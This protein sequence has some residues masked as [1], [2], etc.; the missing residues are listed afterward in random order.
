MNS[1]VKTLTGRRLLQLTIIL[2]FVLVLMVNSTF[3]QIK[4]EE[5]NW[6]YDVQFQQLPELPDQHGFAG[7][8]AGV[9]DGK[10]LAGGGANFPTALPWEGGKKVYYDSIFELDKVDGTW[11]K[12]D[13]KLPTPSGYFVFGTYHDQIVIVAG[14]RPNE[15]ETSYEALSTSYMIAK[16]NGE[17]LL[18]QLPDLPE[19]V[20]NAAGGVVGN[21]FVVAGGVSSSESPTA[22][23]TT[24]ILDLSVEPEKMKWERGPDLIGG[25]RIQAITVVESNRVFL[26]GGIALTRDENGKQTRKVPYLTR[27]DSLDLSSRESR[28]AWHNYDDFSTEIAA[29]PS[30]HQVEVGVLFGLGTQSSD[31]KFDRSKHPGWRK[32]AM[33]HDFGDVSRTQ[34][35]EF[36]DP[37]APPV[38]TAA[39][40]NW[41]GLTVVVSGETRPGVRTPMVY[42]YSYKIRDLE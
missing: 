37:K 14:E 18:K 2:S 27:V 34:F 11:K 33:V 41:N 17:Y 12:L 26:F 36:S 38:V 35:L 7:M 13:F 9:I 39:C 3:A 30:P 25:G 32:T 28:I 42:G 16:L 1:K 6:L 10:L 20:T 21:F 5:R 23:E 8:F 19:G 22:E 31:L 15:A 24:W 40:A 29:G 4:S